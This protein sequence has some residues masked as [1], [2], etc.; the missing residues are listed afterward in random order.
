M[1]FCLSGLV[2]LFINTL[3][4]GRRTYF[5]RPEGSEK[6]GIRYAF[7]S[8]MMPWVKESAKK[9]LPTYVT[10]VLFHIGIFAAMLFLIIRIVPIEY[11]GWILIPIRMLFIVSVSAGIGL[12]VKRLVKPEMA[13][14]SC[15][16]D[17]ISNLTVTAFVAGAL[18]VTLSDQFLPL[19]YLIGIGMFFYIPLG[20]I[21]HCFFFFYTRI[22]FGRFFGRRGV[23]PRKSLKT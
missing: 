11:P 20:K 9:H 14:I 19:F 18:A 6:K 13:A 10:G 1:L 8:G 3:R 5:S 7:T 4:F 17:Y 15:A 2:F 22:L 23:Y 16:D 21:R 12:L